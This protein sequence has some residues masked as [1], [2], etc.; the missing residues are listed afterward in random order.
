MVLPR[1]FCDARRDAQRLAERTSLSV[2]GSPEFLFEPLSEAE[3]AETV[4]ACRAYGVPLRVLGGGYN[5]LV[6]E[7]EL[8]GA[9]LATRRLRFQRILPDR[10]VVGAGVPFPG[11]V[12]DAI[13]LCVPVV[14]GCPGIPGTI[15]GV[16]AMNAGGR[17]GHV[18]E[19]VLA[20]RWIDAAG[21]LR[22][23]TTA[24]A[25]FDYRSSRFESGVVTGAVFRRD[26]SLDPAELKELHDTALKHKQASQ[27]LGARSAGCIF[28]NPDGPH[29]VQSAGRLID[30]AGLKGFQV[31][32]ARV[33]PKH[34]NFIE[35]AGSASAD[36]V[37]A[38]IRHVRQQVEQRFGVQLELEV[39]T[40]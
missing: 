13:S 23:D 10:V 24:P 2:G 29:G 27:P 21:R 40:W 8:E 5:L 1:D 16:I 31:G 38:L 36:D 26:T 15:G 30:E 4:R 17:F 14:P 32:G 18:G 25:D 33:S 3:A 6:R 34:A 28:K 35:N 11:F 39:R 19:A 37:L 12:R 22:E 7:G 9:V 20:V